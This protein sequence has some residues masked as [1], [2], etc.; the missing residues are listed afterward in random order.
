[1]CHKSMKCDPSNIDNK[2]VIV[3][4]IKNLYNKDIRHRVAGAKNVYTLLDGFK[5]A[6]W[7]MF[8][9]KKYECLVSED[10]SI[11]SIHAVSQISDI[12][13]L[14]EHFSKTGNV[15]QTLLP[16]QEGQF[17]SANLRY[18]NNQYQHSYQCT[19]AYLELA[20]CAEYL[21]T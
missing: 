8:K 11:H 4:F 21:A 18:S 9:L 12:S 10:D 3:L 6:Q 14:N 2:L 13:K 15:D 16:G 5:T 20:T 19:A 17:N 1:M 7:S